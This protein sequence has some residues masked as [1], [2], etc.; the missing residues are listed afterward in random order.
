VRGLVSDRARM[1]VMDAESGSTVRRLGTAHRATHRRVILALLVIGVPFLWLFWALRDQH[2]EVLGEASAGM[3]RY[4]SI[5]CARRCWRAS[6]IFSTRPFV[7]SRDNRK[8]KGLWCSIGRASSVSL[9]PSSRI[10]SFER[11]RDPRARCVT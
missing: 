5:A 1:L 6:R 4:W 3:G 11:G 10:E 2:L 9:R 8:S 7:I